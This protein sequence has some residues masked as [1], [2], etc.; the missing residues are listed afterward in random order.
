M[1]TNKYKQ[2]EPIKKNR[3]QTRKHIEQLQFEYQ[4]IS[5]L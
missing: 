4:R 1:D 5:C 3:I 2:P